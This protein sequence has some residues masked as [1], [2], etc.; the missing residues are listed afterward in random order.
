MVIASGLN[1]IILLQFLG[2][3]FSFY[4]P[5]CPSSHPNW[6]PK[7]FMFNCICLHVSFPLSRKVW[8]YSRFYIS[9]GIYSSLPFTHRF[10][11]ASWNCLLNIHSFP[12]R[13]VV[14]ILA[15]LQPIPKPLLLSPQGCTGCLHPSVDKCLFIPGLCFW[16][17]SQLPITGKHSFHPLVTHLYQLLLENLINCF[18]NNYIN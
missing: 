16:V 18:L 11:T 9:S 7:H 4:H 8:S 12:F 14:Y 13:E 15:F 10:T 6:Q 5:L 2:S 17:L 1:F 3:M